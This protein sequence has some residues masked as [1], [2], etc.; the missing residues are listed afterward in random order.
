M[1]SKKLPKTDSIRE[2]A[3]FWDS[4]D[5]ADFQGELTEVTEPVF[6]RDESI[7]LRETTLP[8]FAISSTISGKSRA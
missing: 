8:D 2:L 6:A 4:H 5:L 7:Q 3:R 1:K